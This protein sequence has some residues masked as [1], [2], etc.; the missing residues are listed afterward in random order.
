[1]IKRVVVTNYIGDRLSIDLYNPWETGFIVKSISG[2]GASEADINIT[3]I[4][5]RDGGIY[6][7]SRMRQRNI[8]IEFMFTRT[9][10]GESIEDVRQK[11]YKYFP[12]KRYVEL[13]IETDNRNL[14]ISGYVESN[15]PEI[16]SS[17]ENTKI[18]IICPDP[19]FYSADN[20]GD[21][22]TSFYSIEPLFEFPFSNESLTEPLLLFSELHTTAE[23]VVPYSGDSEV[24]ITI[25]IHAL[26]PATNISIFNLET[27]EQMSI[28][29]AKIASITGSGL[30]AGDDIFINTSKGDKTVTFVREGV[31]YNIMNCL[32][33]NADWF[34]LAK[35]DN[36]FGFT[37]D[38]GLANLQFQI[39]N[40]VIYEGV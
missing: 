13:M 1:M 37:A 40:K 14:M 39:I 29:T 21:N 18:S 22:V 10:L 32:G 16:F 31:R 6:N 15:E 23:G 27:R 25:Y 19:Y 38:S 4:V 2:L 20:G 12:V 7:S 36:L 34:T 3:D 24:G 26:G 28:D 33:K 9:V 11:T 35:G 30:L 8:V 17:K 5:T